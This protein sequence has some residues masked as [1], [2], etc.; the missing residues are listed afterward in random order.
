MM[1]PQPVTL[2]C[3]A[4]LFLV[5]CYRKDIQFEGDPPDTHTRLVRIDTVQPKLSTVLVDSFAT[6]GTS[7]L[8]L[9][10]Y[11]DPFLGIV[12]GKPF[13]QIGLPASTG[14]SEDARYDSITLVIKLNKYYYGDTTASQTIS[15]QELNENLA[16]SYNN[17]LYNSSNFQVKPAVLGS[18]SLIIRPASV[19]SVVIRLSDSKGNELFQMLKQ[20][21]EAIATSDNFLNYFKGIALT[22]GISDKAGIFGV[23]DSVKMR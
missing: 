16:Y 4:L 7:T 18:R 9:G 17:R 19:D 13:I 3:M 11:T 6:S 20:Q 23:A 21:D 22:T 2:C 10:R 8:L 12:T 14:L 1:R 5:S 15:V